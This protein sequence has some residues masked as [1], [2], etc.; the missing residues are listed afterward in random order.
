MRDSSGNPNLPA[1]GADAWASPPLINLDMMEEFVVAYTQRLR[2][3]AGE[4]VVT[5]GNW[6][7]SKIRDVDRFLTQKLKCS[8]GYLSVLDPD[9]FQ[10]GPERVK[11]F[12]DNQNALVTAG[13]DALLLEN[14]PVEAI[15]ERIKY[16]IDVM[17]RDG[18]GVI[19]LNQIP[20]DTPPE[21]IHAAVAACHTY[22]RFPIPDNLDEIQFEI[23]KRESFGEFLS[24]KGE[25]TP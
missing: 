12:A 19:F 14:G 10:I 5:Q 20:A 15:V 18:R 22:G 7:G 6:G 13:V 21:H 1:D 17:A 24:R 3:K 9:L 25:S 2:A 8:P 11:A 4:K 16:Y 23:P